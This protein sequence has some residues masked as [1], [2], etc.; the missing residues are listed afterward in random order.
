MTKI[1]YKVCISR[2]DHL[3]TP[4]P[5]LPATVVGQ[6]ARIAATHA[7]SF[8]L[9]DYGDAQVCPSTHADWSRQVPSKA[10]RWDLVNAPQLPIKFRI[11]HI[12]IGTR[13]RYF[14][15]LANFRIFSYFMSSSST[16]IL[17][18]NLYFLS[19]IYVAST[20]NPPE[21]VNGINHALTQF[22]FVLATG[23]LESHDENQCLNPLFINSQ[24]A[25][26][27]LHCTAEDITSREKVF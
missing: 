12:R 21:C 14:S 13:S 2:L 16:A 4:R 24:W 11:W 3:T 9:P 8:F 6:T 19:F 7:Y 23:E 18:R 27:H 26:A 1:P 22:T 10:C 5:W 20:A 17:S 25:A 15:S